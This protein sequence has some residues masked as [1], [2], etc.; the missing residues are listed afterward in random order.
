MRLLLLAVII[1]MS[2]TVGGA[3]QLSWAQGT[4][5]KVK[6]ASERAAKD[7]LTHGLM[8]AGEGRDEAAAN[9]FRKAVSLRPDW[10]EARSLLG[11]ALALA[12]NYKEA[13]EELRKAVQLK[14]DYA[15]GWNFLGQFLKDRG[16][17][18]EAE[19]AFRKAK[20]LAR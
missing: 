14:P 6:A 18:R 9:S 16:K 17:D 20:Q 3:F 5:E 13:E 15:E 12:G 8:L 4:Q 2:L 1:A 11:S 19:E 10:A 7:Y